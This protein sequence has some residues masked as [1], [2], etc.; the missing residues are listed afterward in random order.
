[1]DIPMRC[2][3]GFPAICSTLAICDHW[4][5]EKHM[6]HMPGSRYT[7][8]NATALRI[9]YVLLKHVA[10]YLRDECQA[11]ARGRQAL[12][13]L[14]D[15]ATAVYCEARLEWHESLQAASSKGLL[16]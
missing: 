15:G 4:T 11:Y 5:K 7:S 3:R 9:R 2:C 1:M 10:P 14:G 12:L 16:T 13:L 6:V 8:V